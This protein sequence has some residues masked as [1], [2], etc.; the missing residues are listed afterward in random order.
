[1]C[2]NGSFG[3]GAGG[4]QAAC[5]LTNCE[6]GCASCFAAD[7]LSCFACKKDSNNIEFYLQPEY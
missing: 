2:L 3:D 5:T 4:T 7:L 6:E 1:M